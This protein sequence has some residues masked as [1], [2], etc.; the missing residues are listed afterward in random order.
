MIQSFADRRTEQIFRRQRIKGVSDEIQRMALRKILQIDAA[1]K[2]ENLTVPPGNQLEKLKG[3]RKGQHS[4]RV[5]RQFR[6]C[7]V[8]RDGEVYDVEFVDYH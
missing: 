5:N 8:W 2:I 4:I 3:D 6:I 7:F 1:E